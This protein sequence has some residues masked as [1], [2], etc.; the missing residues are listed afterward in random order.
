MPRCLDSRGLVHRRPARHRATT[1]AHFAVDP[2]LVPHGGAGGGEALRPA[3]HRPRAPCHGP[4][5]HD[6]QGRRVHRGADPRD[7][8]PRRAPIIL[9]LSNPNGRSEAQP[10]D[11]DRLDRRPRPRRDRQPLRLRPSTRATTS[12][13]RRNNV[14]IFPGVGLGALV[15]EARE[16][17]DDAFLVAADT[18]AAA[19]TRERLRAGGIYPPISEL[20]AIA[21]NI[22]IAVVTRLRD[23]GYGRQFR[24]DEI[25]PAVDR[26]MWTPAYVPYEAQAAV[27]R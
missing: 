22:A 15:A 2:P 11:V 10:A 5:R 26:A 1:S 25:A 6:R 27:P 19:V 7:G 21:R 4:H 12:S 20:R 18:L 16:V 8:E 23:T 17:T 13:A 3:R 24:D 14:F 9:P